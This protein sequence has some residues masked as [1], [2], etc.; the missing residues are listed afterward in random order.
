MNDTTTTSVI[1]IKLQPT[2]TK[3]SAKNTNF[4]FLLSKHYFH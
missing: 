1:G 2:I 4:Y 3:L